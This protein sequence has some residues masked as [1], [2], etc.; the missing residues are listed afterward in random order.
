[1]EK[2][3]LPTQII[4]RGPD[5]N[6]VWPHIRDLN[7]ADVDSADIGLLIGANCKE[8]L[9]QLEVRNGSPG[10][11]DAISTPLGWCLLGGYNTSGPVYQNVVCA[12]V[13]SGPSN[14]DELVRKFW[15]IEDVGCKFQ[16]VME[17]SLDD[18]RAV[19]ILEKGTRFV[20]SR[21]EVPMLFK[22]EDP[23]LGNNESQALVRYR[24]LI[25]QLRKNPERATAYKTAMAETIAQ[26]YLRKLS[27]DEAKISVNEVLGAL[28]CHSSF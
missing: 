23:H 25:K 4:P 5:G 10:L 22:N 16:D 8:A 28:W 2:L 1:M 9:V 12:P 19:E 3:N 14:L 13:I 17:L 11:P 21:Y 6:P 7:L 26:H 27:P 15:S 24:S 18:R 20:G